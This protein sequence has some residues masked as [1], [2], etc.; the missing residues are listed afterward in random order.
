MTPGDWAA[1]GPR[2]SRGDPLGFGGVPSSLIQYLFY[3]SGLF[4]CDEVVVNSRTSSVFLL[5]D[6]LSL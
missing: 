2:R 6:L 3:F 4:S 5:A 1:D